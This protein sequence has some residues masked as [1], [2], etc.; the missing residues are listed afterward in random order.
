MRIDSMSA[1]DKNLV[2]HSWVRSY[3]REIIGELT[4]D[5]ACEWIH[6]QAQRI[7]ARPTT[8]VLVAR[9]E[10]NPLFVYG[11]V[12]A[13]RVRDAFVVHFVY[14]KSHFRNGDD[15]NHYGRA[16]YAAALKECGQGAARKL[17]SHRTYVEPTATRYGFTYVPAVTLYRELEAA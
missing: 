17:A 7:L 13:E 11:W 10:A 15:G 1:A 3:R 2:I 5:Q 14:V 12:C 8:R 4:P 6:D 9:N 16:L